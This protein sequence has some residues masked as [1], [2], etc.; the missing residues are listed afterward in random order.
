VSELAP[1]E[2]KTSE[3]FVRLPHGELGPLRAVGRRVAIALALLCL[4][5]L[6]VW[7][8]RDAY[9][10]VDGRVTLIDAA[11]YAT[12]TLSTTGY[13]DITPVTPAARLLNIFFITPLRILFLIVLVGTTLE[14]LTQR[15][16]EQWRITRWRARV[17]DH[18]IVVGYGT[19]GRSAIRTLLSD[20]IPPERIVVVDPRSDAIAEA[21]SQGHV[22]VQGDATR[23]EVL[24]RAEVERARQVIVAADRDDA[25][26]LVVLTARKQNENALIVAAV[27]E[28][29]NA[30]LL[31]QS[32]ADSVVTSSDAAG[33][34]LAVAML[35][36]TV[37]AVL[38]DLLIP[39]SG[40][41]LVERGVVS[42]EVGQNPRDLHDNVLAVIRDG[43]I[44]HFDDPSCV[45]L[46]HGDRVVVARST[47]EPLVVPD[48]SD[49]DTGKGGDRGGDRS[50]GW[51]RGAR[52]DRPDGRRGRARQRALNPDIAD[53]SDQ[54]PAPEDVR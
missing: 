27:R 5:I 52:R 16:R 37:A 36:P 10:D 44:H 54:P 4:V 14:V 41:E 22:G 20:G 25:A 32:G 31:H 13:G 35:N 47:D 43:A 1:R 29:E 12:V 53:D 50:A 3:A 18:V 23:S 9:R 11:Y 6:V 8:D 39:G 15:T 17:K 21:N 38:E 30:E 45:Q 48:P 46:L 24:S 19:K 33:R 49:G 40:L 34:L 28:A 42:R 2:G 26:V 51:D 7:L